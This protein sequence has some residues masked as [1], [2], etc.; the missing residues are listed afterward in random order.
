M[1]F[2]RKIKTETTTFKSLIIKMFLFIIGVNFLTAIFKGAD[3]DIVFSIL[4]TISYLLGMG[5]SLTI[6][7]Y[8]LANKSFKPI[9][10]PK[11]VLL[12][13]LAF[14]LVLVISLGAFYGLDFIIRLL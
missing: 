11:V 1:D 5:I 6:V 3:R 4:S 2:K 13:I 8:F 10:I 7:Y 12:F 9:D 14:P